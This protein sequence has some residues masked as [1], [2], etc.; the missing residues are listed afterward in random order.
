MIE[1]FK[2]LVD[3]SFLT[4]MSSSIN[5]YIQDH[6]I[7]I[8]KKS[9]NVKDA[10]F[11][12]QQ[13]IE[14]ADNK[15]VDNS[16]YVEYELAEISSTIFR[17]PVAN[18]PLLD[19]LTID[20]TGANAKSVVYKVFEHKGEMGA[21]VDKGS[22]KNIIGTNAKA[23]AYLTN[24]LD[25]FTEDMSVREMAFA[26]ANN[27]DLQGEI[28]RAVYIAFV[29]GMHT[30]IFTGKSSDFTYKYALNNVA[31]APSEN[32]VATVAANI[33]AGTTI[34]IY[35]DVN[36]IITKMEEAGKGNGEMFKPNVM[37]V[38]VRI[39]SL[40]RTLM[41]NAGYFQGTVKQYLEQML[42][43][44]IV[45]YAGLTDKAILLNTDAQNM[46]IGLTNPLDVYTDV[47]YDT[48]SM[49]AT[50]YT[51]GLVL[52]NSGAVGYLKNIA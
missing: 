49:K 27:I 35:D 31:G 6:G 10:E 2:K 47:K 1:N 3:H 13:G 41:Q 19:L 30:A 11:C 26:V 12:I 29:K 24:C 36:A 52:I 18:F 9:L 32:A 39:N 48:T 45:P 33:T 51:T 44:T 17:Q 14:V 23:E 8:N 28:M 22:S 34:K 15:I 38:P 40:L 25:G 16:L 50:A 43:L 20:T 7:E 46:R 42:E 4:K 37:L 21:G 5:K